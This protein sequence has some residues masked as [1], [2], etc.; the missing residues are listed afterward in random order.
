M[1]EGV[2]GV[3]RHRQW[4]G[5]RGYQPT[6]TMK[7]RVPVALVELVLGGRQLAAASIPSK[8]KQFRSPHL[9]CVL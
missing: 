5:G 6:T 4:L 9:W 2:G 1:V 3:L 8:K 7:H